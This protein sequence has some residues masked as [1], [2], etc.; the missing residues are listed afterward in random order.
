MKLVSD[1]QERGT[2]SETH[3]HSQGEVHKPLSGPF[4]D[5]VAMK[6]VCEAGRTTKSSPSKSVRQGERPSPHRASLLGGV[7]NQTPAERM[8]KEGTQADV[9]MTNAT[10]RNIAKPCLNSTY[11]T[12]RSLADTMEHPY[13]RPWIYPH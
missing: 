3:K 12:K 10:R 1:T 7:N 6:Q 2:Q 13:M 4:T 8:H 11:S 5:Q 9:A